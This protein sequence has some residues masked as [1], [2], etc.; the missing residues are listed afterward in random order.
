MKNKTDHLFSISQAAKSCNLSRSTLLRLEDRGLLAPAYTEPGSGRRH[1]DVF[2]ICRI[3][4]IQ[5]FQSM[6]F[7]NEE[8][9]SYYAGKG[10]AQNLLAIIEEKLSA[11]QESLEEMLLRTQNHPDLSVQMLRLPEVLCCVREHIGQSAEEKYNALYVYLNECIARGDVLSNEPLFLVNHQTDYL[12]GR[13]EH[14]PIRFQT[15]VPVQTS[16]FSDDL[17]RFPSCNAISVLYY[18]N[19]QNIDT[20]Y[21]RLGEEVK[22]RN[23]TPDGFLR[24]IGVVA[25]YVGHEI[26]PNRYCT[27]YVLPVKEAPKKPALP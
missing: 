2:N 16:K 22:K 27:R 19:Y 12:D 10:E 4:Q 15:C 11:L 24:A 26:D 7:T 14:G 25:P 18:G 20:A 13:L 9:I 8:T 23:L 21:Y 6:G 3:L 5:K 1:Y 17:V